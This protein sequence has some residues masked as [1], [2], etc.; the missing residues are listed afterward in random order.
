[1]SNHP[2]GGLPD[3]FAMFQSMFAPAA[4][5]QQQAAANPFALL[6]PKEL[7]RKIAETETVL[8]WL[9]GTMGMLEMSLQTMRYQ[10]SLLASFA[11]SRKPSESTAQPNMDEFAKMAGAMNPAMWAL[12][13]M[14]AQP[15]ASTP[16]AKAAKK[17]VTP[18]PPPSR[19]HAP[20][21]T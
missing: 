15:A 14:Q 1:M 18:P 21:K 10:Q 12:N 16:K 9:K 3:Y 7:E 20:R 11:E 13:L 17:P 19:K 2:A 8:A 6:D 4:N 5:A